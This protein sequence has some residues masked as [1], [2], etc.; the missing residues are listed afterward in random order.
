MGN[1]NILNGISFCSSVSSFDLI[2]KTSIKNI[3]MFENACEGECNEIQLSSDR[4]NCSI[5]CAATCSSHFT[6]GNPAAEPLAVGKHIYTTDDCECEEITTPYFASKCG[7]R[8]GYCYTIDTENCEI[9]S[10]ASCA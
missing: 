7:G 2:A 8:G 1:I 6:D 3:N 9:L 5:A 10:V 4:I